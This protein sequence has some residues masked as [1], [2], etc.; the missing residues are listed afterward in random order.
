LSSFLIYALVDPRTDEIRYVGRSS[1]G[2]NGRPKQKHSGH[3]WSWEESL[4]KEGLRPQVKV[5]E[6]LQFQDGLNEAE[7]R[8][9]TKLRVEGAR[10]TNL[11]D[12]GE[13][14]TNPSAEVREKMR[15]AKLGTRHSA[16]TKAKMS[17][18]RVGKS[19]CSFS[20]ET[21]QKM[22]LAKLGKKQ[23]VETR[24]NRAAS[25]LGRKRGKYV[26]VHSQKKPVV[27]NDG[28]VFADARE[29]GSASELSLSSV[30]RSIYDRRAIRGW[31]FAY[32]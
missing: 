20:V 9:I 8:W 28:I 31:S 18:S 10:L 32:V 3:C 14:L 27:R 19:T 23:S 6:E 29:A 21:R 11:T 22:R 5:L 25:L 16:E 15:L 26:I 1:T 7:I 30:L 2:V 17:A 13:G 12:G 4:L 24:K